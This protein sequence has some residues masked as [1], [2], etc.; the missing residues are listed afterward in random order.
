M[1]VKTYNP[2]N[3]WDKVAEDISARDDL[4]VIAGDDEPY[5]RY[6][7]K[8][9]LKLFDTVNFENKK[10]LEVGSGPG[11]NLDFLRARRCAKIVGVDI[12]AK[13]IELSKRLLQDKNIEVHKIDGFSLPFGDNSF[14]LVFTSTVLQHITDEVQ[15]KRLIKNICRVSRSEVIVCERIEKKISGHETNVG[16]PVDYYRALFKENDFGLVSAQ[17]LPIQ[18]SYLLCGIIRKVFN[19]RDRKEGEPTSKISEGLQR[20]VLPVTKLIDRLIPSK[21][22]LGILS[23]KKKSWK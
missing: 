16:R 13:M 10:V 9:F 22:D 12:S 4:K 5:Y 19:K 11:G 8:L 21:R 17:Y 2:E 18:A 1:V 14:D 15:L 20:I 3:Y 7:R 23:F 6:K